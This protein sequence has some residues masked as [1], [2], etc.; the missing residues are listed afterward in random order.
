MLVFAHIN[1]LNF[2]H[3]E[4][5]HYCTMNLFHFRFLMKVNCFYYLFFAGQLKIL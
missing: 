3:T 1:V 5:R 4:Y 2:S